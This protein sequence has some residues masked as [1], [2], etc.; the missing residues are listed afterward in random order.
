M[1]NSSLQFLILQGVLKNQFS[2]RFE[3]TAASSNFDTLKDLLIYKL[4]LSV[5]YLNF[6][7]FL[8]FL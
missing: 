5:I 4:M 7:T 6:D 1:M 8:S 3:V 2:A